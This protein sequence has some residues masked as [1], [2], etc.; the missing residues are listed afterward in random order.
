MKVKIQISNDLYERLRTILNDNR[1]AYGMHNF[2]SSTDEYIE[3]ILYKKVKKKEHQKKH[4]DDKNIHRDIR[5][6]EFLRANK[7]E[8]WSSSTKSCTY[9]G[10]ELNEKTVTY[11]HKLS[12]LRGGKNEIDNICIACG[13]CNCDKGILTPE[14]YYYKQLLNEANGIIPN[15]S[16]LGLLIQQHIPKVDKKDTKS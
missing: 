10:I 4:P 14:E 3:K 9:C 16:P 12:P 13:W 2:P 1:I 15:Q 8:M 7:N 11:D 6:R 5:W